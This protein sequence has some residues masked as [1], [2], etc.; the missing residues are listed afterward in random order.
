MEAIIISLTGSFFLI[1]AECID[2]I[3]KTAPSD[4]STR[5]SYGTHVPTRKNRLQKGLGLDAQGVASA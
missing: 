5:S 2:I 1:A 3:A 4:G